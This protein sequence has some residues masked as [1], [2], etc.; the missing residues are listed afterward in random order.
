MAHGGVENGRLVCTFADFEKWGIRRRFIAPA[1]RELEAL[2]F[3]ATTRRG[4]RGAAGKGTPSLYASR[5]SEPPVRR[6]TE[7]TITGRS[8]S[9]SKKRRQSRRG[10]ER[11]P[12]TEISSAEN[13]FP[14]A[15]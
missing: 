8:H 6:A 13:Y 2:G 10:R 5:I 7:V 11:P 9:Q 1:L 3:I 4:Y 12:T 15:T 14:S